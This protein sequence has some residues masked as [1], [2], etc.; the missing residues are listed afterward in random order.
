MSKSAVDYNSQNYPLKFKYKNFEKI[1]KIDAWFF[2]KL[3]WKWDKI[4]YI[5]LKDWNQIPV[6]NVEKLMKKF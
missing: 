3:Y 4:C 2:N 5:E 1:P 6:T